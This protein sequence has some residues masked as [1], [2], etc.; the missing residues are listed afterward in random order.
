MPFISN[1][2][3]HKYR[4]KPHKYVRILLK[5][6]LDKYKSPTTNTNPPLAKPPHRLLENVR[7]R[8]HIRSIPQVQSITTKAVSGGRGAMWGVGKLTAFRRS[9]AQHI[10]CATQHPLCAQWQRTCTS[11]LSQTDVFAKRP[12]IDTLSLSLWCLCV[13][14]CVFGRNSA[15]T[16]LPSRNPFAREIEKDHFCECVSS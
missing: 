13:S 2:T 15:L 1:Y 14:V 11:T 7:L 10:F 3:Q 6:T 12:N 4:N 8:Q 16:K 9:S 5:F